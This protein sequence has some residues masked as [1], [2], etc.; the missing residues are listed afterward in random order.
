MLMRDAER[1]LSQSVNCYTAKASDPFASNTF[2]CTELRLT[3]E[4]LIT[5]RGPRAIETAIDVHANNEK[6]RI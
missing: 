4:Y 3:K 5:F 2:S 1:T 6:K